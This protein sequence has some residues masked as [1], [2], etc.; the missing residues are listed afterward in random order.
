[1]IDANLLASCGGFMR[2]IVNLAP[3]EPMA[4]RQQRLSVVAGKIFEIPLRRI[5]PT[6]AIFGGIS[7]FAYYVH[8]CV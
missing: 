8:R 7:W 1:M 2:S 3:S 5:A 6:L 4:N